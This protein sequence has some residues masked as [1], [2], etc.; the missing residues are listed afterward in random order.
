MAEQQ[1]PPMT[2]DELEQDFQQWR[3]TKPQGNGRGRIPNRLWQKAGA[4]LPYFPR[5]K[6]CRAAHVSSQ[7][8]N[9]NFPPA[10]LNKTHTAKI[11]TQ[12]DFLQINPLTEVINNQQRPIAKINLP[13]GTSVEFYSG[14]TQLAQTIQSLVNDHAASLS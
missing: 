4:L 14:Y 13:H 11:T 7:Q 10:K 3:N 2:L 6:I 5:Y 1:T 12:N 9:K 8:L